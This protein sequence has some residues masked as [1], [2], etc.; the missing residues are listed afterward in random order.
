M[1][2]YIQKPLI[3]ALYGITRGINHL[4]LAL[5]EIFFPSYRKVAVEAPVFIVSMPRTGTTWLQNVIASDHEQF[6]S[7]KLWEMVFAPSIIQKKLVIMLSKADGHFHGSLE[8]RLRRWDKK[9]F[10]AYMPAHPTSFFGYEDD[11]LVMVNIFSNLFLVFFFPRL[12]LYD[13]LIRFDESN[14]VKRKQRIMS[15]YLKCVQKHMFVFGKGRTY[16]S[17]SASHPPRMNSLLKFFPGCRFIYTLRAPEQVIPSAISLV[18]RLGEIFH[19][20]VTTGSVPQRVL[21]VCDLLFPCPLLIFLNLPKERY[22]VGL[23]DDLVNDVEQELIKLYNHLGFNL[24]DN[25]RQNLGIERL[26]CKSYKSMHDYSAEK[27]G[28]TPEFLSRRY[29]ETFEMYRGL[30]A[31]QVAK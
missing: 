8:K 23:Y 14:N 2:G 5:D 30:S 9:L 13:F 17:K 22:Y 7:M 3:I 18:S 10:S 24:N 26:R 16:L 28:Y 6:T 27:W 4:C 15:F 1:K 11:D 20:R 19:T 21:Q 31:G 12:D 29:S 25:F